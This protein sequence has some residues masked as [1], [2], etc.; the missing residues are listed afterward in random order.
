MIAI[1]R[2]NEQTQRRLAAARLLRPDGEL[3]VFATINAAV[4]AYRERGTSAGG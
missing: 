2:A 1:A 4:R 3:V